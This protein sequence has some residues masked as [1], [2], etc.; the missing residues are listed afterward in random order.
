MAKSLL[1]KTISGVIWGFIEK[2]S[3]HPV[4]DIVD[5][6]PQAKVIVSDVNYGVKYWVAI[7]WRCTYI[8]VIS[9]RG[10]CG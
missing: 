1:Q 2:F 7:N 8:G 3:L 6:V 10:G 4:F 9:S 5:M